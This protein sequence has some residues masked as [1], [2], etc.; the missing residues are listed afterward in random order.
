MGNFNLRLVAFLLLFFK[1][2][3]AGTNFLNTQISVTE[4]ILSQPSFA[5]R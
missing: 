2:N 3:V 5:Q 1:T 4:F